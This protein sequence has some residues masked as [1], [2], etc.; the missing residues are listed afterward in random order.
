MSNIGRLQKVAPKYGNVP[1]WV[2]GIRF[3]SRAEARRYQELKLLVRAGAISHLKIQPSY[4]LV[5]NGVKVATYRADF[6]YD[7]NG[8]L[9]V[10]DVKS[11]P[12]M[13][14][15]YRLKKKLLKALYDI[16]I[17]EVQA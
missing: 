17:K 8:R 14:P 2:D 11:R 5:V 13:T 12:T 3:A 4:K 9:V 16:D 10:E 6:H 1:E 15:V 7:E